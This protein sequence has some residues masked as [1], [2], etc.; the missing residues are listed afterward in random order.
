MHDRSDAF[1]IDNKQFSPTP[2]RFGETS[3]KGRSPKITI[4]NMP[5]CID[6]EE[7]TSPE[8]QQRSP[9]RISKL[10]ESEAEAEYTRKRMRVA[11]MLRTKSGTAQSTP[12]AASVRSKY[13]TR[14]D[15]H[16]PSGAATTKP[17]DVSLEG[18]ENSLWQDVLRINATLRSR[19]ATTPGGVS[20]AGRRNQVPGQ[21]LKRSATAKQL[22]GIYDRTQ[23]WLRQMYLC[24]VE[25]TWVE[26]PEPK[27]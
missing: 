10:T 13:R 6:A 7:T 23:F 22:S 2:A 1:D 3:R 9:C 24:G 25:F 26:R 17:R 12:A 4:V 8:S 21:G 14:G 11:R 27:I 18:E 19:G 20:A 5:G 15:P 16:V